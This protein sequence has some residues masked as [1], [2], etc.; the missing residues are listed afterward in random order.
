MGPVCA[1]RWLLEHSLHQK[2]ALSSKTSINYVSV[3]SGRVQLP[4]VESIRP[5][6][7]LKSA[8]VLL[9]PDTKINVLCNAKPISHS[10]VGRKMKCVVKLNRATTSSVLA[11]YSSQYQL[12]DNSDHVGYEGLLIIVFSACLAFSCLPSSPYFR[13]S[14]IANH[15]PFC[16]HV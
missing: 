8:T 5:S 3:I 12:R 7:A 4:S 15:Y 6:I 10:V 14:N 1:T 2:N 16:A 9:G 11:A 13:F